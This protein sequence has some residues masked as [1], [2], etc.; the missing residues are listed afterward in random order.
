MKMN[1]QVE[2]GHHSDFLSKGRK[3][4]IAS[5]IQ[6]AL[7]TRQADSYFN[8]LIQAFAPSYGLS[9]VYQRARVIEINYPHADAV[10]F[11]VQEPKSWKGFISGQYVACE[12]EI[13]GIRRKRNYSIC[14]SLSSF[15]RTGQIE[16]K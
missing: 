15:R 4:Q 16:F 1:N 5:W 10:T 8:P 3:S 14:S 6:E 2:S 13:N 9:E 12:F 7:L 11:K